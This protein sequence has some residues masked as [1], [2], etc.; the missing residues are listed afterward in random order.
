MYYTS[1]RNKKI[2]KTFNDVL[3]QGLSDDG[4]L[5]IPNKFPKI[6][7]N[8]LLKIKK[9]SYQD[10]AYNVSKKFIGNDIN[11][12]D[13]KK[14]IAKSFKNFSNKNI[15]SLKKIEESKWILELF[16][17]PTLAFKDYALQ[18]VGN[19]FDY[20]LKK[21]KKKNYINWRHIR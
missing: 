8:E 17:G 12:L 7:K 9:M 18:V 15:A 14:I 4:G 5:F 21:K 16:H 3:L 19:L 6:S 2:K 10:I 20:V 1:T 13:L 11:K